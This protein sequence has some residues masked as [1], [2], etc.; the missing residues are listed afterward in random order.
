MS[1]HDTT[2]R[3]PKLVRTLRGQCIAPEARHRRGQTLARGHGTS[4]PVDDEDDE[5]TYAAPFGF[6]TPT[7]SHLR[8]TKKALE[9]RILELSGSSKIGQGEK[10][11]RAQERD[12]ASKRVRDGMVEKQTQRKEKLVQEAKDMGNYHPAFKRFCQDPLEKT[13]KR[14]RERG[15]RMG[16]DSFGGGVL[17]P[18]KRDIQFVQGGQPVANCGGTAP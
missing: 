13:T 11:V 4:D 16:I 12:K 3:G 17:R 1:R 6:T 10:I 8:S 5:L 2:I 14:N 15:L 9:G 7:Q 18:N